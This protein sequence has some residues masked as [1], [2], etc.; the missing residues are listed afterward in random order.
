MSS[1]A[2]AMILSV[3]VILLVIAGM[4]VG[5]LIGPQSRQMRN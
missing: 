5:T 2:F 1:L 4:S 3:A